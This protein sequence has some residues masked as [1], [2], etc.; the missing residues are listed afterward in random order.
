MGN[1][2]KVTS[3]RSISPANN[4][5]SQHNNEYTNYYSHYLPPPNA[6][7]YYSG[8]PSYPL[9]YPPLHLPSYQPSHLQS[10]PL[11]QESSSLHT[12]TTSTLDPITSQSI[13]KLS[14]PS[15][16]EFLEKLD[17]QYGE[18]KY[19]NYLQKFEEE[20]ITVLQIAEMNT[21]ILLNEFG[22]EII[23]RRLNLIKEAKK[24]V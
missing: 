23:G 1:S 10:Y 14:E 9:S 13:P 19:S 17:K 18:G 15:L 4:S 16:K 7:P 21:E 5:T 6:Y 20:E 11:S 22:I 24:Y 2:L 12:S 3:T 8:W